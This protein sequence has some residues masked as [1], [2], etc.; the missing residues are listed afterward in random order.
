M[1]SDL[2]HV[3]VLVDDQDAALD[4]YTDVLGFEKHDDVEMDE[5]GRWL[6]VAP[7]GATVPQLVL[8][9]SEY[10]AHVL[11]TDDCRAEYDRLAEAGV[12]FRG[13]PMEMPWGVEVLFED[14]AGNVFDL[15]EPSE[16]DETAIAELTDSS[17]N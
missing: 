4:F 11:V 14:P 13:E 1:I 7:E 12:T 6:T 17:G 16:M 3:T 2:T 9:D 10:A 8:A 15:L 5:N